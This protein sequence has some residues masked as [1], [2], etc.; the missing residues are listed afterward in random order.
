MLT[1]I[2]TI[3]VMVMAVASMSIPTN[4]QSICGD[5]MSHHQFVE[6]M[7]TTVPNLDVVTMSREQQESYVAALNAIPPKTDHQP[8]KVYIYRAVQ[9]A[10]ML[11][12]MVDIHGCML[13]VD[14]IAPNR[15]FFMMGVTEQ[16]Q[17]V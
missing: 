17:G 12:E 5:T 15:L 6:Q 3:T 10:T 11:V 7:I 4:A 8:H 9:F 16:L 13:S 2:I 1:F 14:K